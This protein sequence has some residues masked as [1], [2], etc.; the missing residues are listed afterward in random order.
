MT[1]ICYLI[2]SLDTGGAE[3]ALRT[4]VRGLDRSRF[5]VVVVS[6]RPVGA[7]G[8][9]MREDGVRVLDLGLSGKFDPRL[10]TRL[11]S[12]LKKEEPDILHTFLSH[13]NIIGRVVGRMA[14][15]PRIVSS[16]QNDRFGGRIRER[17]MQWTDGLADVTA[18]VSRKAADRM[19]RIGVVSPERSLVVYNGVDF[20]SFPL[21]DKPARDAVRAALSMPEDAPVVIS[22]GRLAEQKGYPYLLEAFALVRKNDPKMILLVLGAGPLEAELKAKAEALGLGDSA[23]FL[24]VQA[25]VAS[26]YAAADVFALASLW[27]GFGNVIVEAM[28]TGLPPLVTDVCGA[29]EGIADGISGYIVPSK[30]AAALAQ[31]M[32]RAFALSK[33]ERLAM[34][35]RAREAVLGRFSAE[36][37]VGAY[38]SVYEKLLKK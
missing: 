33:E 18:I 31:A 2:T 27:E 3:V 8:V 4:L 10:F 26:Y 30:D 21:R 20:K 23:R 29:A 37:M 6:I 38:Q 36:A 5:S 34:G 22:V 19:L 28:A 25:D 13:S 9:S 11:Y 12:F 24:G 14:G 17:L 35:A 16:I 7:I 32:G 1:K 15:V